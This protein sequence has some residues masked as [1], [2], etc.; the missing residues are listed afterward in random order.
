MAIGIMGLAWGEIPYSVDRHTMD[1]GPVEMRVSE[2]KTLPY[3]TPVALT[4]LVAGAV[5]LWIGFGRPPGRTS[6]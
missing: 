3:P 4:T 6:P 1:L 2:R 5:I